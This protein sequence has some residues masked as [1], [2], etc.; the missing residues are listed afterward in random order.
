MTL[1]DRLD[2]LAFP[3]GGLDPGPWMTDPLHVLVVDDEPRIR[4]MLRRYLVEEGFKV[5]DAADGAACA[6]RSSARRS[7]S[8]CSI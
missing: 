5:S 3:P 8:C 4:T 2:M 1:C 6:P 7:I